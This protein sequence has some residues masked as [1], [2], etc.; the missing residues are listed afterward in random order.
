MQTVFM[1]IEHYWN[2]LFC[3]ENVIKK[4]SISEPDDSLK[5]R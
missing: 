2:I 5:Y 4:E 3:L 1:K